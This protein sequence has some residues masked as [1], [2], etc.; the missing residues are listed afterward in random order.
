MITGDIVVGAWFTVVLRTGEEMI[1]QLQD[2]VSSGDGRAFAP[3]AGGETAVVRTQCRLLAP[4]RCLG[5]FN[6]SGASPG[7]TLAGLAALAFAGALV[8]ARRDACPGRQVSR[9]GK[10]ADV[11]ANLRNDRKRQGNRSSLAAAVGSA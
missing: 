9:G 1:D 8:V 11:G 6:Q 2:A 4:G 10:A 3:T 5:C 7:T